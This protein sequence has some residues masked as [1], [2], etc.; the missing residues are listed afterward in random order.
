M[1]NM[2]GFNNI[3]FPQG[4]RSGQM[5]FKGSKMKCPKTQNTTQTSAEGREKNTEL[6]RRPNRIYECKH[7]RLFLAFFFK[8]GKIREKDEQTGPCVFSL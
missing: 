4:E 8:E 7:T 2:I 3:F 6:R 5:G 1:P